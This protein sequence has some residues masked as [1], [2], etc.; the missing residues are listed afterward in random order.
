MRKQ[1]STPSPQ[2]LQCCQGRKRTKVGQDIPYLKDE[3]KL[4]QDYMKIV[5]SLGLARSLHKIIISM[6]MWRCIIQTISYKITVRLVKVVSKLFINC[7]F[8]ILS[9]I[10][11]M[12]VLWE[13]LFISYCIYFLFFHIHK[14]S[15][16][17]Y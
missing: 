16:L 17:V 11:F 14:I 1:M 13:T 7:N 15:C 10:S 12:Y 9:L 8:L 3:R 4:I 5:R 6:E 2:I